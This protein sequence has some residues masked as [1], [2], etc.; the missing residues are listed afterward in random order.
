MQ[1]RDHPLKW[2]AIMVVTFICLFAG[3]FFDPGIM[4]QPVFFSIGYP[5]SAAQYTR[6]QLADK[7]SREADMYDEHLRLPIMTPD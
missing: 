5:K 1:Q 7:A 3:V 2:P 4:D 6:G